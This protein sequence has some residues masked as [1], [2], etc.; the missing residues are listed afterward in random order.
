MMQARDDDVR[1]RLLPAAI[2]CYRGCMKEAEKQHL[3]QAL[4]S[5]DL[6][7][8]GRFYFG[9]TTT[10][11]YCRPICSAKPKFQN[12]RFFKSK[13][14][15][16]AAG[17]RPCLKCRPDLSPLSP[18]WHGTAAIMSR[19]LRLVENSG[20]ERQALPQIAAALGISDRHLRRLF[21]RHVGATPLAVAI[22]RRLHFARQLLTQTH[23]SILEIALAAGFGSLRRFN[24]AFTKTYQTS[25]S[26]FRKEANAGAN[27]RDLLTIELPYCAP[28]DWNH[29]IT[30]FRNHEIH[31]VETI[32]HD[33]YTRH[34]RTVHGNGFFQVAPAARPGY[35]RVVLRVAALADLRP[36]I[37][38][39]RMQFDL[40]HN[41][42]RM[43]NVALLEEIK[44]VR[45]PGAFE[46]FEVAVTIIL[47]QMVT[48]A[49]GR[50]N[51]KKL[52]LKFGEIVP[53]PHPGLTH[54]FP[55]A[56]VLK[57]ADYTDLGFTGN[58]CNAIRELA[59]LVADREI[60]LSG[61]C[62]LAATRKKLLG[63]K[64]I[65]PW[66]VEMIALRC[67]CDPDAF[68]ANDLIVARALHN[69][70]LVHHHYAPWR[71]YLALAIWKTQAHVL[72]KKGGKRL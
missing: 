10:G 13:A 33:S 44:Q 25:P 37:E 61:S 5:R 12:V 16:E 8:D 32:S 15:A 6:R 42:H 65:G 28:F 11:I 45:V 3:Y 49:Q 39:I 36:T 67:L 58:R 27:T 55:T 52:V 72:T 48:T 30:F 34:F 51:V 70:A 56:E 54:F 2:F 71:A 62:D 19:A 38:K 18:Q 29:L 22:S 9:V 21:N 53:G 57:N 69:A 4:L 40:A 41:P 1:M 23:L 59:R 66:T 24:D 43:E 17:Y 46:P 64:G 60:D 31:G 20:P 14:D 47:G 68:P 7:N 35:I 26:V 50:Q 63:I